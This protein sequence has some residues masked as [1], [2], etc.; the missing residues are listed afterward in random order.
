MRAAIARALEGSRSEPAPPAG[1]QL[2]KRNS[3][4][5][6]LV[7]K[8]N[9]PP[10]LTLVRPPSGPWTE[11]DCMALAL[12]SCNRCF[13][14]GSHTTGWPERFDVCACVLRAAFRACYER[15]RDIAE[16][17]LFSRLGS[18]AM[19]RFGRGEAGR[20]SWFWARPREEYR[21][22]FELLARRSLDGWHYAIFRL[23]FLEGLDW[24]ACCA[25]LQME[26]GNFFHSVYRI[27]ERLGR[28]YS[29]AVPYAL[30]PVC[31]Y[32]SQQR[33]NERRL[34]RVG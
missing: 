7:G 28:A 6:I 14:S 21:A 25:Q 27:E 32:F 23:H 18:S 20:R 9:P 3:G 17:Q 5:L 33:A 30:F 16:D 12:V 1:P 31:D 13:G 19:S 22:D 2:V 15:W 24:R 8:A 34:K 11:R 10:A 26:R 4:G 29:E